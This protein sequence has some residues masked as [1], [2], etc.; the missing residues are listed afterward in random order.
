ME[1]QSGRAPYALK[2]KDFW[3]SSDTIIIELTH[4][5]NRKVLDQVRERFSD[6]DE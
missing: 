2:W 4:L 3:F 1:L 6:F 5:K